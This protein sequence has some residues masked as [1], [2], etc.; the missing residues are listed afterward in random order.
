[1]VRI[2]QLTHLECYIKNGATSLFTVAS[3]S[4]SGGLEKNLSPLPILEIF[5]HQVWY[6]TINII[7]PILSGKPWQVPKLWILE[8]DV[9]TLFSLP[10]SNL[11]NS[12]SNAAWIIIFHHLQDISLS[13]SHSRPCVQKIGQSLNKLMV[14]ASAPTARKWSFS[15]FHMDWNLPCLVAF[16]LSKGLAW[17]LVG[18]WAILLTNQL[19]K[20]SKSSSETGKQNNHQFEKP[21]LGTSV[22]T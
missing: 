22:R 12:W 20:L 14:W 3:L 10:I 16:L 2:H 6:L 21:P 18:G 19:V 17:H 13:L 15:I 7:C 8:M 4:Q 1:M 9:F 5:V 11:Q